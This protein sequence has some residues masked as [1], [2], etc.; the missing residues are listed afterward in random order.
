MSSKLKLKGIGRFFHLIRF[1]KWRFL[2]LCVLF[3]FILFISPFIGDSILVRII[4]GLIFL[5]SIFVV[6]STEEQ[7]VLNSKWI[8]TLWFFAISF[9]MLAYIPALNRFEKIIFL[10]ETMAGAALQIFLVYEIL[11]YIFK[12]DDLTFDSIFATVSI[13][14]MLAL[15]FSMFY[16]Y[17]YNTMPGS[18]KLPDSQ[19]LPDFGSVK[20]NM[21]Y[22][23]MV[24]I[25]T[26]G[27]GDIVPVSS[28]ARMLAVIEA[29]VGQFFVAVVV[30]MLIGKLIFKLGK[31]KG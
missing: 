30:A 26:L 8:Y 24:T 2:Q 25:A 7:H 20:H 9:S 13:Y 28:A 6:F 5:N 19:I 12:T 29:I 17:I 21:F 16:T 10:C 31:Q 4:I 1:R 23:S 11:R 22:F 3:I 15:V 14:L 18:F 27:Y